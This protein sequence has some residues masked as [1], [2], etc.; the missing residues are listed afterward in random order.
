MRLLGA[1]LAG[2]RARRFGG[3]KALALLHGRPLW[4]HAAAAL[5]GCEAIVACGRDDLPL[6]FVADRPASDLGPL[7]G[8]CAALAYGHA[9]EFD[10]V[11]NV[12]CDVPDLPSDLAERLSPA[13]AYLAALPVA[14]LWRCALAPA[15]E[16]HLEGA[17]DRSLR[18]WTRTIGARA[19]SLDRPLA[20]VNTRAELEALE[21]AGLP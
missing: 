2:G 20:N 18:T 6:P 8:L 14:G 16:R 19:V 1:L 21:N 4:E 9:R 7:G 17:A 15:L 11:L 3:D 12:P 5:G 13:P 10:A